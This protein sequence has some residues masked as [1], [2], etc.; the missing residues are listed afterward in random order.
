MISS[1]VLWAGHLQGSW[2][3]EYIV[4]VVLFLLASLP[5]PL[6]HLK[7]HL[8]LRLAGNSPGETHKVSALSLPFPKHQAQV[9]VQRCSR[10]V[11]LSL[12]GRT[13]SVPAHSL[14]K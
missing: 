1:P 5:W 4:E 2:V 11:M 7:L 6:E 9:W 12:Q 8:W 10:V 13:D 14:Q 3:K